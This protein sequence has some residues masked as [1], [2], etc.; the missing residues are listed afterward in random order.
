MRVIVGGWARS[1]KKHPD[2]Y[3][4]VPRVRLFWDLG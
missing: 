2:F 3:M 1:R 4:W